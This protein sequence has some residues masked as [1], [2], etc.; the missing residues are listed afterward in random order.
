MRTE[1][2]KKRVLITGALGHIGSRLI[3][4]IAPGEFATVSLLDNLAT[5]R[6]CSLFD[7]P[8]G[9]NFQFIEGDVCTDDLDR[10]FRDVDAVVHLAA[11]TNAVA[12]IDNKLEVE[13]VNLEGAQRVAQACAGAG[14]RLVFFST[15]SVY[16][17]SDGVVDE[18]CPA[19]LLKPQSPYAESKL[20]AEKVIAKLG[21]E[22]DLEYVILRAG[23]ICGTSVGMRFHTAVNKFIWQAVLAQPLT[24][25][26]TALDQRRPYL[27]LSDAVRAVTFFLSA[28][29]V[30]N[31]I[32]NLV[33]ENRTIR[34]IVE[35][36]REFIPDLR[37]E[38][39]DSPIMNQLSYTVAKEK[40]AGLGFEFRGGLRDGIRDTIELLQ[41]LLSSAD[42]DPSGAVH[43]QPRVA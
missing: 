43:H 19:S 23:T 33:T 34:E 1:V 28:R 16:G 31:E 40:V 35:M 21:R 30:D 15:T 11:M 27:D 26:R 7:L 18:N 4:S 32:Y 10:L 24:V 2:P 38:S 5:Q 29:R 39:V 3:H 25:W 36:I 12:S 20:Q 41:G 22:A 17:V 42:A 8:K 14:C 6:Y 9:G 13:R 37:L